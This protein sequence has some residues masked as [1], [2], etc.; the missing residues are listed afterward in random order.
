M[1]KTLAILVASAL[2]G[3]SFT[4]SSC[5]QCNGKQKEKEEAKPSDLTIRTD[6]VGNPDDVSSDVKNLNPND[7]IVKREKEIR[8]EIEKEKYGPNITG[9][10]REGQHYWYKSPNDSYIAG[11]CGLYAVIRLLHHAEQIDPDNPDIKGLWNKYSNQELRNI[12]ADLTGREASRN[13]GVPLYPPELA[14]LI[15]ALLSIPIDWGER[16]GVVNDIAY[17]ISDIHN[18]GVDAAF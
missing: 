7:P 13:Q 17:I 4:F 11:D 1:R 16:D 2:F 15:R 10:T 5:E 18:W 8:K 12:L 14:L 6:D 3:L 9:Y